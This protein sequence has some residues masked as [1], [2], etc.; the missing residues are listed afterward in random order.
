MTALR[1]LI[2]AA[3]QS[4]KK[5][6]VQVGG[7]LMAF[8]IDRSFSIVDAKMPLDFDAKSFPFGVALRGPGTFSSSSESESSLPISN[9]SSSVGAATLSVFRKHCTARL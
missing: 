8:D 3:S 4:L 1:H 7:K 9:R 2:P 6:S 5:S